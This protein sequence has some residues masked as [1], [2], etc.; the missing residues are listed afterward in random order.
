MSVDGRH[1][2]VMVPGGGLYRIR[3]PYDGVRP[4][5]EIIVPESVLGTESA[6]A[7]RVLRPAPVIA[8]A[9]VLAVVMA[10]VLVLGPLP[11]V[12]KV[13]LDVNPSVSFSVDMLM[14]VVAVN[15]LDEPSVEFVAGVELL[16]RPLRESIV[17]LTERAAKI[18][19]DD[20]EPFLV[21]TAS[22]A[23][24]GGKV[25]AR[26][27]KTLDDALEQAEQRWHET[28][29]HP[30][31]LEGR[32]LPVPAEV[33]EAAEE[34]GV[35]PGCYVLMLAAEAAGVD[36]SEL[37]SNR[38]GAVLD[39]VRDAGLK[40]GEVLGK[41]QS[42][43]DV[44]GLWHDNRD[45]IPG[46]GKGKGQGGDG[47]AGDSEGEGGPG[48]QGNAGRKGGP[49]ENPGEASGNPNAGR[50]DDPGGAGKPETPPGQSKPPQG[51]P[52]GTPGKPDKPGKPN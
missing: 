29:D 50:P 41:A 17:A 42:G 39:A 52:P 18:V 5:D 16:R 28:E 47:Q 44:E 7:R 49:P 36:V 22:P 27:M 31:P 13:S 19:P 9:A 2:V 12:A 4:G 40:P 51:K 37:E 15:P 11:A 3:L 43:K 26:V 35:S 32:V 33:A 21:L 14:R 8:A 38:A 23:K 25:P 24:P 46:K 30:R 34:A 6:G 48:G 10:V 20:R 45:K 1:A